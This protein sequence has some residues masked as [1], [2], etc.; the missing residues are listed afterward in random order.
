MLT[1]RERNDL[2]K[3]L[4]DSK[5]Y[6]D[7]NQGLDIRFVDDEVNGLIRQ[8]KVR[9][10]HSAWDKYN[11]KDNIVPKFRMFKEITGWHFNKLI[12][13]VLVNFD[14]TFEQD[15]ERVYILRDL[16]RRIAI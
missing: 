9:L 1:D 4:I 6:I 3:Q 13:Y 7:I 14:S 11:E 10:V 16:S 5:A 15:L 2:L 8:P 12:V